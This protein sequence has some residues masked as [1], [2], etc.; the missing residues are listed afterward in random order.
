MGHMFLFSALSLENEQVRFGAQS[1][2]L[3]KTLIP[4]VIGVLDVLF[5]GIDYILIWGHK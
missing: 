5:F 1:I 2:S 4:L 3:K